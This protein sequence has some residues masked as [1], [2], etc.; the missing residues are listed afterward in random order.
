MAHPFAGASLEV[1][2]TEPSVDLAAL[3]ECLADAVPP[4]GDASNLLARQ[5]RSLF[6]WRPS[7]IGRTLSIDTR[8]VLSRL[9]PVRP[10]CP[11]ARRRMP[12]R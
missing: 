1:R 7:S 8:A 4:P 5:R 3:V 2:R 9:A 12:R 6:T 11:G 10:P